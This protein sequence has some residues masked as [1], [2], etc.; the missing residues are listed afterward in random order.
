[1]N[2]QELD[3]KVVKAIG[4]VRPTANFTQMLYVKDGK[5][6][7][8][9]FLGSGCRKSG[10]FAFPVIED[11]VVR[12]TVIDETAD[13][14][15]RDVLVPNPDELG[16]FYGVLIN[17]VAKN[18]SDASKIPLA[19]YEG[20]RTLGEEILVAYQEIKFDENAELELGVDRKEYV[21]G[22]KR[23]VEEMNKAFNNA[24]KQ[25]Q[26]TTSENLFARNR[27]V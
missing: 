7:T 12:F 25:F 1:M 3:D 17:H 16:D 8:K 4:Y 18:P 14:V 19:V 24:E 2:R 10:L 26:V 21:E 9:K 11:N 22:I 23:D 27:E 13:I 20:R 6:G 15:L 5:L